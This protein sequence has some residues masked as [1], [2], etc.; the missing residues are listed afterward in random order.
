MKKC[1]TYMLFTGDE[2]THSKRG[3]EEKDLVGSV[4]GSR[5]YLQSGYVVYGSDI[6]S[7]NGS[8]DDSDIWIEED[9]VV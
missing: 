5:V 8:A 6:T 3:Y 9:K 4:S 2:I 1:N 7:V